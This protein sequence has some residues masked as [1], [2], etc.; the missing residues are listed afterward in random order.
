VDELS[1]GPRSDR[2][3]VVLFLFVLAAIQTEFGVLSGAIDFDV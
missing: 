2:L 3:M 1:I